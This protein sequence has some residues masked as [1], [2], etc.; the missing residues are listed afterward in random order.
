MRVYSG[1]GRA[2]CSAVRKRALVL[3][4][5]SHVAVDRRAGRRVSMRAVLFGLVPAAAAA[6]SVLGVPRAEWEAYR[7]DTFACRDGGGSI[8]RA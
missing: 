1:R 2:V 8:R 5:V 3:T 4:R 7:G 6:Q